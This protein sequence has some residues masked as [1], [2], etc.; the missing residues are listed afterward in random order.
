MYA[1]DAYSILYSWK[2]RKIVLP[3]ML[4]RLIKGILLVSDVG[5]TLHVFRPSFSPAIPLRVIIFEDLSFADLSNLDTLVARTSWIKTS[6]C[7]RS[8]D[9]CIFGC[10]CYACILDITTRKL[11]GKQLLHPL[12][13][14]L[15]FDLFL[16]SRMSCSAIDRHPTRSRKIP[17]LALGFSGIFECSNHFD[18]SLGMAEYSLGATPICSATSILR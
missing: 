6:N 3:A 18:R 8:R 15:R 16:A 5:I 13:A 10:G 2:R 17:M 11:Y 9:Y 7:T 12:W 14:L 1:N 4:R